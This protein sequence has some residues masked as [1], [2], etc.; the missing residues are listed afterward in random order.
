MIRSPDGAPEWMFGWC[1]DITE[2]MQQEEQLRRSERLLH[3]TGQVAGVGGWEVDLVTG[4]LSWTPQ[5]F[6]VAGVPPGRAPTMEEAIGFYAPE[7]RQQVTDA[8]ARVAAQ[9]GAYD[10]EVP[11]IRADGVR[12]WVRSV[13]SAV[14]EEGRAVRLVGAFMDVTEPRRLA[15][16]LAEHDELLQVTL[17][18]IGDAVITADAA[19]RILWLNPVAERLT[20]W[21]AQ[22]ACGRTMPEVFDIIDEDT[23][24]TRYDLVAACLARGEAVEM[25]GRTTLISRTGEEYGIKDSVAPIKGNGG[26]VH[27][28]VVV[29][30][31]E[32]RER[33]LEAEREARLREL[34][35]ANAELDRFARH[36]AQA[37]TVAEQAN[38]AKTRF[39]AGMS[40]ELRTPL[41]GIL[42]YA[43]LLHIDGSLTATQSERVHAMMTAGT[44][45]LEM[46]HC[47]LDLSDIET[48]GDAV[49]LAETHLRPLSEASLEM[50][51]P[52]ASAKHLALALTIEPA[53]P[54]LV[55]AD[56]KRIRQVLLNLLGNAVKYTMSGTVALRVGATPDGARLRFEVADT[57][58]GIPPGKRHRLFVAFDRLDSET[59]GA[60]GAGLGLS[61]AA[62]FAGLMGGSIGHENN[63]GGGSL[64]WLELPLV[65]ATAPAAAAAAARAPS[66]HEKPAAGDLPI[67]VVDDIAMNRDIAAAFLQSAGYEIVCAE[68]GREA[69]AAAAERDW[70]AVLMDVRMPE[71]D[72]LEATR[73]IRALPPPRAAVPI[74]ALTAQ[75]FTDEI[76]NCR[77]AGMDSH[78]AKPFTFEGLLEAVRRGVNVGAARRAS[79]EPAEPGSD[80]AIL[81]VE[82][83]GRTAAVLPDASVT[84]YLRTLI[85]K[86]EALQAALRHKDASTAHVAALA[87]AAHAMAGSAGMFGFE[88]LVFVA[89]RFERAVRADPSQAA[90]LAKGL[91]NTLFASLESMRG[92]NALARQE[93]DA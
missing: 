31:D 72:G 68:G 60:E 44:H 51:R 12:I 41:N 7:V 74:I 22:E 40:H 53:V 69:V 89:K 8:M 49:S 9:G 90:V 10:L 42:G 77:A 86:G 55:M 48:G 13:G 36:L 65:A 43:Q 63:V 50:V 18:S 33:R 5:A 76:D 82:A 64:F 66:A 83:L 27:G 71:M 14:F 25:P 81:D 52:A 3:E 17:S 26:E 29:F 84:A 62:K 67:L 28:V 19:A 91:D 47:V 24:A 46:I 85:E 45:L 6:R 20:G 35:A 39:L 1:K 32:T 93:Q 73:R 61:L 58:P 2:R 59:G 56:A 75:A 4:A 70:L 79:P 23:R 78:V 15:A 80:L 38:R 30:H 87:D 37:R 54:R 16:A 57:G 21:T 11:F 92:R 88:R 34:G